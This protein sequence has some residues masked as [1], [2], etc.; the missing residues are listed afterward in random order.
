MFLVRQLLTLASC[1]ALT[2]F[3]IPASAADS[4]GDGVPD[5]FDNCVLQA[6]AEQ[7]DADEDRLGNACDCDFDQSDTCN[8]A[9]FSIFREDFIATADSGVGT[10]MDGDGAVNIADFSLFRTGFVAGVPGPSG[11]LDLPWFSGIVFLAPT[12][13]DTLVLDWLPAPDDTTP[14]ESMAYEVH[15]SESPEFEPTVA[16]LQE[17]V[18]AEVAADVG[19]LTPGAT[20]HVLVVAV[21]GDGRRSPERDYA[22]VTMPTLPTEMSATTP[23]QGAGALGLGEP[24]VVG[25]TYTYTPDPGYTEPTVGAVLVASSAGELRRVDSVTSS[26]PDL[27][28]ETSGASLSD[29]VDQMELVNETVLFDPGAVATASES[30]G[31]ATQSLAA[32]PLGAQRTLTQTGE[33]VTRLVWPERRLV[34]AQVDHAADTADMRLAPGPEAGHYSIEVS[35]QVEDVT[36]D[37]TLDVDV[38]FEPVI[39]RDVTWSLWPT[40]RIRSAELVAEGT[41]SMDVTATYEFFAEGTVDKVVPLFTR[42][43]TSVYTVGSAPIYQETT[44]SVEAQVYV[45]ATAEIS[46]MAHAEASATVELGMR[47]NESTGEWEQVSSHGVSHSMAA[48]LDVMGAVVGEVRLVPKIE[49]AFYKVVAGSLTAE[50]YLDGLIEA[51]S[52]PVPRCPVELSSFDFDLGMECFVEVDFRGVLSWLDKVGPYRI[53]GPPDFPPEMPLFDLPQVELSVVGEVDNTIDL[54]ATITDGTNNAFDDSSIDWEVDPPTAQFTPAAGDRL[55]IMQCNVSNF[56]TVTFSGH[57][58]PL[59]ELGRRC[60][61]IELPCILPGGF[62]DDF[63]R[64]DGPVG[65]GW[66]QLIGA[67]HDVVVK[68]GQAEPYMPTG[69]SAVAGLSRPLLA[70]APGEVYSIYADLYPTPDN[71]GGGTYAGH[72]N[73]FLTVWD[74][75]AGNGYGIRVFRGVPNYASDVYIEVWDNGQRVDGQAFPN[76]PY[77]THIRVRFTLDEAGS[78]SGTVFVGEEGSEATFTFASPVSINSTG[79]NFTWRTI[80]PAIPP[81]PTCCTDLRPDLDNLTIDILTP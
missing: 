70:L 24:V 64:P 74:D 50:P 81:T 58:E 79:G 15:A 42:T 45:T 37:V 75:G 61:Q 41:L 65:N 12:A 29:A 27:V 11:I 26:P 32:S 13:T 9:D 7:L 66:S 77:R 49:V 53:C 80:V 21:D 35:S 73:H 56:Y 36:S 69:G 78:V 54:L 22:E 60:N 30:R 10:D 38:G 76:S 51:A 52:T 40:P 72:Y 20:Y 33:Q 17:T 62:Y 48:G 47:Y 44:L 68:D 4:D 2:T 5:E 14:P 23:L 63:E 43:Y 55:T 6:N 57:G 28:V 8:I 31:A 3:A 19:G 71:W 59:G 16:T 39:R 67:T 1:L 25:T 34:A 46:A 18:L